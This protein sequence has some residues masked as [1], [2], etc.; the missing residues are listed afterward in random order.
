MRTN[1]IAAVFA[2]FLLR[3]C[4]ILPLDALA[5]SEADATHLRNQGDNAAY[6]PPRRVADLEYQGVKE[7][8]GIVAST[9]NPGLFWTHN[10][11]GDGPFIYAFDGQG[12]HRGVWRVTGALAEDWEDIAVGPG[13][14]RGQSYIY[15]GDIG[16]NAKRRDE[17]VVYRVP[18]PHVAPNDSSSTNESPRVT[19]SADVIRLRYPD[20]RHDAEALL[21]HPSTGDLYIVTKVRAGPAGVYKLKASR[22]QQAAYAL[23][24][25]GDIQCPS[26][27]GGFITGGDISRDGRRVILC[28]YLGAC[29]LVLPERQG[30]A[31]DDI[32]KQH[33]APINLGP[34][35]Q[36]EAICYRADRLALMVTSEGLPCPLTEIP[37]QARSR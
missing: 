20:G 32:W 18:E 14:K 5:T 25:V 31:F 22:Q 36:G 4:L 30:I 12:K 17:V 37:R 33:T 29:E 9:R 28:D 1:L 34:R 27:L 2:L 24:R 3:M 16:D 35:R 19:G 15:I 23:I 10:D 7:S 11:S 6:G 13:P 21:V 26:A 8:S